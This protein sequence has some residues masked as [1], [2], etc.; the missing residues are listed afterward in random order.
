MV[1][2]PNTPTDLINQLRA[3]VP[4]EFQVDGYLD[5]GGQG[6][7][8]L[9]RYQNQPAALKVFAPSH[10]QRRLER[11]IALLQNL[12]HANVVKIRTATTVVLNGVT[13]A[14]VAY[15]YL[16]GGDLRKHLVANALPLTKEQI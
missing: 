14:L 13:C 15:E 6:A 9:G 11:E 7:V 10:D 3:A 2:V 16:P 8:F 1:P 5:A 4:V 12:N